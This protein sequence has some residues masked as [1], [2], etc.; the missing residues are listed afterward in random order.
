MEFCYLPFY[1]DSIFDFFNESVSFLPSTLSKPY[2]LTYTAS[3][4]IVFFTN[5]PTLL[6]LTAPGCMAWAWSEA[7]IGYCIFLSVDILLIMRRMHPQSVNFCLSW[8]VIVHAFYG[9]PKGLL[10][11]LC[12]LFVAMH[13]AAFLCLGIVLSKF[14]VIAN[15]FP[16]EINVATCFSIKIP[17]LSPNYWY[18][19]YPPSFSITESKIYKSITKDIRPYIWQPS[20][21]PPHWHVHTQ[22]V[23]HGDERWP[24]TEGVC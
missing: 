3:L 12:V 14:V 22:T 15:P 23:C 9:R 19:E 6:H 10:I 4:Q 2:L 21:L 8:Y 11:S 16:P 13:G 24:P 1:R 7:I 5:L 17:K 18:V 20:F